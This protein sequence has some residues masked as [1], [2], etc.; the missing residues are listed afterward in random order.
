MPQ[1]QASPVPIAGKGDFCH[2]AQRNADR[3]LAEYQIH[4]VTAYRDRPGICWAQDCEQQRRQPGSPCHGN[5]IGG[6]CA[7]FQVALRS[8]GH[9]RGDGRGECCPLFWHVKWDSLDNQTWRSPD[10]PE[11]P[12]QPCREKPSACQLASVDSKT[13][14]QEA[15]GSNPSGRAITSSCITT[16][17]YSIWHNEKTV[18]LFAWESIGNHLDRISGRHMATISGR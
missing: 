1:L 2:V 13:T 11:S 14:A 15:E 8:A 6:A 18:E 5:A 16:E 9:F 4:S 10:G 17:Q 3:S 12:D 7:A